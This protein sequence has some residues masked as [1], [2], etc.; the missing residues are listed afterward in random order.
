MFHFNG[1]VLDD[2]V[3]EISPFV[4]VALNE[5]VEEELGLLKLTLL[6]VLKRK[7]MLK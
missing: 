7:N 5:I 3:K 1:I 4:S 2:A 6:R